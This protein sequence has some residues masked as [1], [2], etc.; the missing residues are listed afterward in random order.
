MKRFN[1]YESLKFIIFLGFTSYFYYL[2]YT[3]KLDLFINPRMTKH[4]IFT[5]IV[6]TILSLYQFTKIFTIKTKQRI[7]I[8]YILILLVLI[9][10]FYATQTNLNT[11]IASK[12]GLSKN[13]MVKNGTLNNKNKETKSLVNKSTRIVFTD[14]NYFTNLSNIEDDLSEKYKG[15]KIIIDGFIYKENTFKKDQFVISRL[16]ITCCTADSQVV[17]LMCQSPNTLKLKQNTWYK[18]YGIIDFQNNSPVILVDKLTPIS[19]P[20]NIYVYPN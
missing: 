2:I 13:F 8:D 4:L 1:I 15:Q 11:N 17:G 20:K 3:K 6:F 10:G 14:K 18:V 9:I 5:C 7:S 16:M 19:K 12:K